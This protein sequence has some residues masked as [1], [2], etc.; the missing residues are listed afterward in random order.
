MNSKYW[1]QSKLLAPLLLSFI[2]PL[3]GCSEIQEAESPST[4]S[5]LPHSQLQEVLESG[6]EVGEMPGAVMAISTPQGSWV[7]A[8]GL[9]NREKK[10]PMQPKDRFAIASISK[11][12]VA[13][14]VL[15]LVEEGE[16][17]LEERIDAYLPEEV[18]EEIPYSDRVT[19]RQLLNHT[20]GVAE[21]SEMFDEE[22]EEGN[23]PQSWTA[24]DAIAYIYDEE[25]ENKPGK[26]HSYCNSNYILLHLIIEEITQRTL[27]AEIRDRILEPAGL[28]DTFM[29]VQ[30]PIPGGFV[31]GYADFDGD[32]E[33][34]SNSVPVGGGGLGDGGLVSTAVDLIQFARSLFIEK[35]LLSPAMMA[36]MLTFIDDGEGGEYGLGVQRYETDFGEELGHTGGDFGFQS[37]LFYLPAKETIIA[38]LVNDDNEEG[39]VNIEDLT[40]EGLA[41]VLD[42]SE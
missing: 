3:A 17:D 16:L 24:K 40:E 28:K 29:A 32:G 11:T 36:E 37:Q 33:W 4:I 39:E 2:A 1:L 5:Q 35:T 25:P 7:G 27:A 23:L 10:T 13:V 8:S 21:Y 38:V 30:E 15:Q 42:N 22:I 14:V 26:E 31:T 41:V 19:V 34:D 20:S 6:V 12:F 9:S 18:S